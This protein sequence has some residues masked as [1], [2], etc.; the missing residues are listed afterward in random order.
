M[1]V[2]PGAAIDGVRAVLVRAGNPLS[3]PAEEV[4]I[5]EFLGL[6]NSLIGI[7]RQLG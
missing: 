4:D 3:C 7:V 6:S 1:W 5:Q 2:H